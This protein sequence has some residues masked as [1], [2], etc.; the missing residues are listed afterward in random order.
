M[1]FP[2]LTIIASSKNNN[3]DVHGGLIRGGDGFGKQ[4]LVS[5]ISFRKCKTKYQCY[6][7]IKLQLDW[8]WG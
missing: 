1:S 3:N 5:N 6:Y 2:L 8:D 7:N 4:Y